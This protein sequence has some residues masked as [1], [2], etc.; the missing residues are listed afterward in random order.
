MVKTLEEGNSRTF[1]AYARKFSKEQGSYDVESS[2]ER[3]ERDARLA[4]A[5]ASN[6]APAQPT[7]APE[8][9]EA[10]Q[11]QS[12]DDHG[13]SEEEIQ[14]WMD[15]LGWDRERTVDLLVKQREKKKAEQK[16]EVSEEEALRMMEEANQ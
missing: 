7:A 8:Q 12:A 11:T 10:A 15:K 5:H 16:A 4:E 1:L 6:N 2:L 3:R 13:F 14:T 9:P